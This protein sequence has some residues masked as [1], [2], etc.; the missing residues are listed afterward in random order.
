MAN[1]ESPED[2]LWGVAEIGKAIHRSDRQTYHLLMRGL[3]PARKIGSTW[4]GSR[5]KLLTTLTGDDGAQ[6]GGAA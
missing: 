6:N 1:T 4:V 2:I 5:R 3:L